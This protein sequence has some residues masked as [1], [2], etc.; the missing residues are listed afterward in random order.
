MAP[1]TALV[2]RATGSQGQAVVKHLAQSGWKVHALVSDPSADRAIVLKKFGNVS[3]HKG[4]LG[5]HA[6]IEAAI[7]GTDAVFLTQM[8]SFTDDSE[9]QDARAVLNL[10][11]AAG[12]KHIIHSTQLMLNNPNLR[13]DNSVS[14]LMAPAVI[15]KLDVEELVRA[16]GLPYT[17]LRPGWFMTNVVAPIADMMYPG[18]SEGKFTSSYNP[19][20]IIPAVDT[21]DV[22]AFAAAAFNDSENFVGK[23]I[24]VVSELITVADILAEIEKASGKKLEI[25]YR[26]A[27]ETEKEA[28]N[29]FVIGQRMTIGL[30][31][32]VDMDEVKSFGIP[33]TSFKE[34]LVKNKEAVVP[35]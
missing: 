26:T 34:F 8:P 1:Q 21:D 35:K 31:K 16:S 29:P 5:D 9:I 20:T 32:W 2:L 33:L 19:D 12:V 10:A 11:K 25:H 13:D 27:E 30:D 14:P 24:T 3:L 15:R 17:L 22:G 7:A 23:A 18:L 4:T 6:S 28:S